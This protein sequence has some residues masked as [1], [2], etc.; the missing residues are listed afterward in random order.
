MV[1]RIYL[2][3]LQL[4]KTNSFKEPFL[5]L[6]LS[7]DNGIVFTKIYDELDDFVSPFLYGD[8]PWR[9][10]YG[11]LS[12]RI[13]FARASSHVCDKFSTAKPSISL[14]NYFPNNT[15]DGMSLI[16]KYH[17][18]MKKLLQQGISDPEFYGD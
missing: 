5:D 14:A 10:P 13:R 4:N 18:S 16:T 7:T 3:E 2:A 15:E 12:E 6:N 8:D 9:S 17:D 1:Y 11:L